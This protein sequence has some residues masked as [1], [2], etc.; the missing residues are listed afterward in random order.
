MPLR[1]A[2]KLFEPP[3][4]PARSW[5]QNRRS[6]EVKPL[7][8]RILCGSRGKVLFPSPV[9]TSD[10]KRIRCPGNLAESDTMHAIEHFLRCGESLHR[11]GKISV[12]AFYSGNQGSNCGQHPFEIEAIALTDQSLRFSEIEDSTLTSIGKHAKDF[13]QASIVIGQVA[14]AK[15]GCNQVKL[16]TAKRKIEGVCLYPSQRGILK[17]FC[18]T[19]QHGMGKIGTRN[20]GGF[21]G[22]PLQRGGHIS[23]A[24]TKI[25]YTNIRA[26]Q[27][28]RERA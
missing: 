21:A 13:T 5:R 27:E 4:P 28:I 15:R 26:P 22:L 7:T 17:F 2:F 6:Q 11:C 23:G 9:K 19:L 10:P 3:V 16:S 14:E 20:P 1:T 18:R 12:W 24:T 8:S 25:Q